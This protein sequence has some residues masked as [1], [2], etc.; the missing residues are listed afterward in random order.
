MVINFL[1][2]FSLTIFSQENQKIIGKYI[3]QDDSDLT[4]VVERYSLEL[5]NNN[6]FKYVSEFNIY[7]PIETGGYWFINNDTIILDS[8]VKELEV[9]AF[10]NVDYSLHSYHFEFL[11]LIKGSTNWFKKGSSLNIF[12]FV[13]EN[14]D[15]LI[16]QPDSTGCINIDKS[17][18]IKKIWGNNQYKSNEICLPSD[19]FINCFI[20]KYSPYRQF[21]N[22]KWLLTDNNTIIPFDRKNN[23]QAEYYLERDNSWNKETLWR[24]PIN[25]EKRKIHHNCGIYNDHLR[26]NKE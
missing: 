7:G 26:Q 6:R 10:V 2:Y 9:D 1:F 24:E 13:T 21:N 8:Q 14:N 17:M 3:M 22:E 18:K 4:Q 11:D 16:Y 5:Y 25:F 12:Y 19:E 23:R 20:V 15:T